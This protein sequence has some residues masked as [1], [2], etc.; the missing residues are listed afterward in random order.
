V[1]LLIPRRRLLQGA[2]ALGAAAVGA[3]CRHP[4]PARPPGG[5]PRHGFPP[6]WDYPTAPGTSPPFCHG[7]AS[8]D[9]LADRVV[10]WTRLTLPE[11]PRGRVRV[12]WRVARDRHLRDVVGRGTVATDAGRDWTVKVDVGGLDPGTTYYY[13][14]AARG[15]T[16]PVGRTKTAPDVADGIG[17]AVVSCA[18]YWS[19]WWNAYD[20]IA[21]R[22]DVDV[23]L[24]CG[25]HVYDSVDPAEWVR[26]RNDRFDPG[27][28][29][30]RPWRSLDEA[31]RRYALHYAD[32]A[33]LALHHAHPMTVAWDNH[34]V[35]GGADDPLVAR[36]A[37][38]E[39]TPCRPPDPVTGPDGNVVPADV[40]RD[41]RH[42]RYGDVDL[43]VL[44][45]RTRSDD[46][47]ILGAE[48]RAWFQEGL[49]ASAG[50]RAPWRVVVNPI[51]LA[52]VGLGGSL[53]GGWTDRPDDQQS[54][55]RYLSDHGIDDCVFVAGDAHGAFVADLPVEG[56]PAPYDPATGAG[57]AAVEILGNSVSRGGGDETIAESTY[58]QL[59]GTS[60]DGDRARFEALLPQAQETVRGIE[61]ALLAANPALKYAQWRDHGYGL[62]RLTPTEATLEQWHVPI[63]APSRDQW[64]G[65]RFTVA[66]GTNHVRRTA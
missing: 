20:R 3:A 21:E 16:S 40:G 26:A 19:G 9:P 49:L 2:V 38:W 50:R 45:L 27:Y 57:S 5:L 1:A 29:D 63:L 15:R 41:H 23:V 66:R 51:P 55:L 39:W 13:G 43:F 48:Q 65:A 42:L 35:D 22:D 7:V 61:E 36:R 31:R 6:G 53:Y 44:D 34:D 54:L 56:G 32:P 64:L 12:R 60:P 28:V 52:A 11:A 4:G 58:R 25:D 24:H 59:Y 17:M 47:T 8:G 14:F 37:F 10:V 46:V 33:L 62:V 18:S 30:F